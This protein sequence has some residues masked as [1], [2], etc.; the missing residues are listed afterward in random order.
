[1]I[2]SIKG[3]REKGQGQIYRGEGIPVLC[4]EN[5]RSVARKQEFQAERIAGAKHSSKGE[6]NAFGEQQA[7][8]CGERTWYMLKSLLERHESRNQRA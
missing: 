1:M 6:H 2:I 8:P 3:R 4:L 5:K 7:F